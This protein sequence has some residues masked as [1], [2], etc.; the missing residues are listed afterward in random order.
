MTSFVVSHICDSNPIFPPLSLS[1]Y[2]KEKKRK[3]AQ[4]HRSIKRKLSKEYKT[5]DTNTFHKQCFTSE[6]YIMNMDIK[7]SIQSLK[8]ALAHVFKFQSNKEIPTNDLMDSRT[9]FLYHNKSIPL[10][11][12]HYNVHSSFLD[13]YIH[14]SFLYFLWYLAYFTH[15]RFSLFHL[16]YTWPIL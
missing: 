14:N 9:K 8:T 16:K 3:E 15:S 7:Y 13:K 11:S 10:Y 1:T 12:A 5:K 2:K 4:P 6:K